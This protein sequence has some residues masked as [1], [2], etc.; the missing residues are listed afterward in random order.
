M[1]FHSSVFAIFIPLVVIFSLFAPRILLFPT[2]IISSY[3]FYGWGAGFFVLLLAATSTMDYLLALFFND[4]EGR[5]RYGIIVSA[6]INFGVLA[7]FKYA[8]FVYSPINSHQ[9]TQDTIETFSKMLQFENFIIANSSF[10]YMAAFLG[11]GLHSKIFY[12]NPWFKNRESK[13]LSLN[14]WIKI[15]NY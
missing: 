1:L 9:S 8:N 11:S 3:I 12:P 10:S 4:K 2:L 15:Q 13:N 14:N 7:Y 6:I 5:K